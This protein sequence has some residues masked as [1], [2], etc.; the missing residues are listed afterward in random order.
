MTVTWTTILL[1]LILLM[2]LAILVILVILLAR[3]GAGARSDQTEELLEDLRQT[4]LQMLDD[5]E[6]N[7]TD[8][9]SLNVAEIRQD[10]NAR[11]VHDSE[12]NRRNRVEVS[13]MLARSQDKLERS[14]KL[15]LFEMQESNKQ[16]I[17][18]IQAEINRKL[19]TSLNERLDAS[20][21]TVGE[22][23]NRLYVSLGELSKLESG[24]SS[25][26]RTLSNVKTRGIYGEMQLENILADILA[27]SLY[28]RNV[29]TKRSEGANREAVEFAVK[30][31]DKEAPGEFMYLPIDSKFPDSA[32]SRIMKAAER[33]DAEE[34]QR[35]MRELEQRVRTDAKDI[36]DKYLD[37]PHTTDFGIMFLP[38]ESLYAEVLRIPGLA[39]DC[40]T[41]YHVVL[42]GPT[43][44]AALLNSLSI[45]FRYMAVNKDSRNILKLLAAIKSQYATLSKLI[46]TAGTRID[47]ARKATDDL[48]RRADLINKKLSDVEELDPVESQSLLDG[49]KL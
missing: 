27:P 30:I 49:A 29:V 47:L 48:Q 33:A 38:T 28:D 45:G 15:A 11:L 13:D 3:T 8:R 9:I 26:N 7:L 25:L 5:T 14:L 46:E 17:T 43:T 32:Y 19:D 4:G 40:R 37:P 18:D 21:R 2:L 23:L 20:F 41:R 36:R 24:V 39:E 34:M 16:N 12:E 6:D 44:L 35:G 31:P 10:I 42:S 1:I 22:Q